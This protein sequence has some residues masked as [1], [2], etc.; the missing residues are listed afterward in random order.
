MANVPISGFT[1]PANTVGIGA[2]GYSLT[3]SASASFVDLAGTW[4]TTGTPTAIKLNVT[5]TASNAASLLMDLQVGGVTRFNVTKA[6]GVNIRSIDPTLRL[7]YLNENQ[8]YMDIG[9]FVVG[10]LH[11]LGFSSSSIGVTAANID[12]ILTRRGA[13]NLRLGAA[14]AA[15]S[16]TVTITIATPGVVT[17][18]G[19][20]L[21][22]GTPVIF[23]T[24]GA[25]PTGITAG[26]TYYVIAVDTNTFRIATSLA[27]ALAGTAVNTS[28]S[29]SGTH[30]GQRGAIDQM[31]SVQ[32]VVAGT[33][34]FP[35]ADFVISGSQGT[36]TGAGGSIVFQ[37][38]P[39]GS[40]GT[41]QNALAAALTINSARQAEFNNGSTSAPGITFSGATSTGIFETGAGVQFS[42]SG[43]NVFGVRN[44]VRVNGSVAFGFSSGTP[45]ATG[46][47]VLLN[48]DAANTLALR[49]GTNAQ[50]F[51]V[52]NTFTASDNFERLRIF[53]QSGGSVIIGTQKGTAGGTARALELQTDGT[54]RITIAANG[55]VTLPSI[56]VG[57]VTGS[58]F[59]QAGSTNGILWQNRSWMSS[60]SDG[61]ITFYNNANTDFGRLQFGGTTSSFPALK[62]S[63]TSLQARLADDS[64]FTNIQGK[65]TTE[66]A[67]TAGAPTAT[68]YLVL[69]DS[70]GTAYK[71]PAEA[72]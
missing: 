29:Q 15:G 43:T 50:T 28:G 32:S 53:A 41:A 14:D 67:Y 33:T 72:L 20:G 13:A 16:A 62:R 3:G 27:N 24:T 69:Y 11:K 8:L 64:A 37:V 61:V 2:T 18:S 66:T 57:S 47:D 4:N 45:S 60:P 70:N 56:S 68:G 35:G 19:H 63:T 30:T 58:G 12:T 52:Y 55:A 48:R 25:L 1:V 49:N 9:T 38:A 31:L 65:L 54:T 10:S 71:V 40:S 36:G 21:S 26:T 39:A 7:G 22:T 51:N 17:W 23:S 59:L 44:E 42:S 6:G 46:L 34:N 5:D